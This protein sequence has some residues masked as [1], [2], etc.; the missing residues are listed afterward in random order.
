MSHYSDLNDTEL[1]NLLKNGDYSA[2]NEL[3]NRHWSAL[4]GSAYNILRNK[5]ACQ[6]ILQE[7][8]VWFWEHRT[9]WQLTSCKGYLL[10]AVKFKIANYIRNNKVRSSFFE[11]LSNIQVAFI[12][13]HIG[14]EVRQLQEFILKF[15]EQ[16]PDR[17]REVFY[18]SRYENLSNK[19]IAAKLMISEKTVENQITTALKKLR[20]KLGPN[21]LFLFL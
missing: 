13:D 19:E 17:C 7:V 4:Y 2:F 14:L 3:Y 18:L 10:T 16:L 15:T 20:G 11:K 1:L 21:F 5:E 6:D 8:F 12:E 9:T